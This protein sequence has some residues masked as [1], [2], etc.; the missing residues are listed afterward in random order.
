MKTL[1]VIIQWND[2]TKEKQE[3]ITRMFV[4]EG[5]GAPDEI[6]YENAFGEMAIN[7]I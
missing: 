4:S 2:L 7:P 1:N 6:D 5:R 3:E